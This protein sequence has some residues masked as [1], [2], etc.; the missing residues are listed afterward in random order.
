MGLKV[1]FAI[2]GSFCT[3]EK[4]FAQLPAFIEAGYEIIP[5]MSETAYSTD[6]RFGTAQSFVERLEKLT[7][8]S[9]IHTI[10]DAEPF[11]PKAL[12]D[13]L[14]IAPCTGNTLGKLAGGI[15]DTSVT[16]SVK[17]HLRNQRPVVI[18]VSSNDALAASARNI[19]Q[20]INIKNIYF[21][22]MRQDD[23][24]KKPTSMVADMTMILPAVQ[25]ALEGKQI[26]PVYIK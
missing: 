1:G 8:K 3:F 15:T 7:G 2:T 18:A 26:Q 25:A 11:G 13:I 21:V 6:T 20:L 12:L 9:V 4:T 16:M 24:V 22:P 23:F 5:I 14:V 19:G 10:K 17:A